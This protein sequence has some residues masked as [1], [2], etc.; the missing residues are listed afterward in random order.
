MTSTTNRLTCRSPRYKQ[1]QNLQFS[2]RFQVGQQLDHVIGHGRGYGQVITLRLESVFVGF[3]GHFDDSAIWR[4]VRVAS[5][6]GDSG[7]FRR[8]LLHFA[9]LFHFD[10]VRGLKTVV[11]KI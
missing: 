2:R 6:G 4:R 11:W 7:R 10:A 5:L 3:P 9:A 1:S 8:D